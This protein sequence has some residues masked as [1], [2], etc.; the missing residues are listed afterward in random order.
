MKFIQFEHEILPRILL[1]LL[2]GLFV[3]AAVQGAARAESSQPA[4]GY[5]V[6]VADGYGV[7]DCI[8]SGEDCAKIVADAWCGAHGHGDARAYG[9]A[10][11]ITASVVRTSGGVSVA[12]KKLGDDDVF[13]S[14]A[15]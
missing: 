12:P 15:D 9:P 4:G 13:I 7:N 11:D 10:S 6:S 5:I 2:G 14:C 3:L 8:R 1:P